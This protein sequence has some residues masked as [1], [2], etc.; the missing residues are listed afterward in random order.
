M[1][2]LESR[3]VSAK[4]KKLVG[5]NDYFGNLVIFKIYE[6]NSVCFTVIYKSGM[7]IFYHKGNYKRTYVR[8]YLKYYQRSGIFS[9]GRSIF[10]INIKKINMENIYRL[11]QG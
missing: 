2:K 8:T 4:A 10:I 5:S 1:L 9:S 7:A 6:L 3:K 11:Y